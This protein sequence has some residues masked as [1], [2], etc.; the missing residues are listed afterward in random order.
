[1]DQYQLLVDEEMLRLKR[2]YQ[3]E[4]DGLNI[5][6]LEIDRELRNSLTRQGELVIK[7]DA[8]SLELDNISKELIR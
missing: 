8:L 7:L 5:R 1:M 2:K 4:I 6:N 3:L